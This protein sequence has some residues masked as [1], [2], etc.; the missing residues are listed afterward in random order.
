[1]STL[2]ASDLTVSFGPATVLHSVNFSIESG[3]VVGLVGESGSGKSTLARALLG[4]APIAS[5]A[6]ALGGQALGKLSRRSAAQRKLIQMVFQD[7][8]ASL[9][10]RMTVGQSIREGL[11][12]HRIVERSAMDAE[13]RRLCDMV[14]MSHS[15]VDRYPDELSGGQR[16]RIAI[17]RAL[18]VRPEL[19]ILDEVT[20][21]LDVSVQAAILNMLV[22]LNKTLNIG[23]LFISHNLSVVKYVCDRVVVMYLGE[24]VE[25]ASADEF[26]SRAIHPYSSALLSA[27]PEFGHK[28]SAPAQ[29]GEPGSVLTPPT[30]CRFHPRCAVGPA[31]RNDRSICIERSPDLSSL[32]RR[33]VSCHFATLNE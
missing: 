1:M 23:M 7:P 28:S 18:A 31:V 10:P 21:A 5:G 2:T 14:N 20:S 8:T 15:F 32:G 22:D 13:V 6:L 11:E 4:I 26:F 30:G 17:A 29:L 27:I 24:I 12:R 33:K 19:L 16:Q 25:D 3:T 9:N